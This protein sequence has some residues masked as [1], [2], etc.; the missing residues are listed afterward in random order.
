MPVVTVASSPSG[1]PTATTCSPTT[2][3]S[4]SPKVSAV[5]PFVCAGS[6]R[7]TAMS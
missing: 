6:I 4:E 5:S 2:T 3:R 1:A 7:S